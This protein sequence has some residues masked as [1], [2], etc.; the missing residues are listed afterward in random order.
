MELAELEAKSVEELHGIAKELE[1]PE[2]DRLRKQDLTFKILQMQTEQSGFI[3]GQGVLEILP[4][5][6]GFLRHDNFQPA[7]DDIYVSQSQ[8]KRFGL[9]TGDWVSGQVRPPKENEKYYGLLRVEAV[10]QIDPDLARQ[11]RDFE[12][13]TPTYP[14]QRLI[15][16]TNEKNIPG[17]FVDIIAPI[18]KGQR[19]LIVSPPK[20]GKTTLLKT[21]ANSVT[22][23]H[24][25]VFLIVLLVDERPEEVTDIRRSV[26]GQ[27]VSSTF[28]E[29]PEN[30]IRVAEMVLD[31]AKRLVE[32]GRDV[33]V[34][35]DSLT[36]LARASN[37]TVTP[38]G[39]TLTGGL[40][41]AAL[42][43][44]KRFFGAA[45]NIEEGGSLTIVA[46]ALVDTGSRMDDMIYEEFKGTGNQEIHLDRALQ[47]RRI[48]PAIDIK[49]SGT[50]HD[51]LL[52]DE[53]TLKQIWKLHR[54]LAAL[55]TIQ[56]TELL[57]DR[58]RHT[59][60]NK[61]FLKIVD[62]TLKDGGD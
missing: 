37:L 11:R 8:I 32:S 15:L 45:R 13:L 1:I 43:R 16:E 25:E 39:R 51:E 3:F 40:D 30:H 35:L 46:T 17:R 55:D 24:P 2:Y 47:E 54:A 27:V 62:K 36:R 57:I 34:L 23:N 42:Y 33:V 7:P 22:T 44:P 29:L 38:S 41:P 4:D 53:E 20:A 31:E 58:L 48:F 61:E 10:N 18:G 19:S 12:E 56:A 59:T 21:I 52:Y 28:D 14:R 26:N 49:K 6:W 5:G 9:K 50:R 60:S